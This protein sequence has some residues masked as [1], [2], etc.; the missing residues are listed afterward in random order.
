MT[1]LLRREITGIA[2]AL[3][4]VLIIN[5]SHKIK[6]LCDEKL[7]QLILYTTLASVILDWITWEID[8]RRFTSAREML[9][10]TNGLYFISCVLIPYLWLLYVEYRLND[11][12]E[13]VKKRNRIYVIPMLIFAGLVIATPFTKWIFYIDDNNIYHRGSLYFV[14]IC[15]SLI[16]L[17]L[18]SAL[19]LRTAK[20]TI[21]KSKKMEYY[22][23][24]SF[25]ITPI[26]GA[27]LQ[28]MFYGLQLVSIAIV[29]S[30]LLIFINVQNRQVSMDSLTKINNRGQ[31][32]R[33]LNVRVKIYQKIKAFLCFC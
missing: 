13:I 22:V 10:V 28:V 20:K 31:L 8:G 9:V 21:Q 4:V 15:I 23:F 3:L 16:Y 12:E 11:E 19:T 6:M 18:A 32:D 7:F 33:F 17:I 25:A 5:S 14:Q 27:L 1:L 30:D 2:V 24:A 29:F 26:L